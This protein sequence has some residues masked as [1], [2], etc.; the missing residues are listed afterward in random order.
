MSDLRER[1]RDLDSLDVPDVMQQARRLGPKTPMEPGPR[2][3]GRIAIAAFALL[4]AAA[5]VLYVTRAFERDEGSTPAVPTPEQPTRCRWTSTDLALP[6]SVTAKRGSARLVAGTS[7]EDLWVLASKNPWIDQYLLHYDGQGWSEVPLPGDLMT[8]FTADMV[9]PAPDEVWL[10]APDGVAQFDGTSWTRTVLPGLQDIG[11]DELRLVDLDAVS[12]DDAWLAGGVYDGAT[13]SRV[14][15]ILHWDGSAWTWS[16]RGSVG[17]DAPG[18]L[19]GLSAWG[20]EDVW[21]AGVTAGKLRAPVALHWD[22]TEWG[23]RAV[24]KPEARSTPS[25][26]FGIEAIGADDALMT[27][28]R[29][30]VRWDGNGWLDTGYEAPSEYD[31]PLVM[32]TGT[33]G[34]WAKVWN[35]GVARWDGHAWRERNLKSLYAYG[36]TV[37]DDA[38]VFAGNGPLRII[39][40]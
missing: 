5:S 15:A 40:C 26:V 38:A 13:E 6:A 4:V 2:P 22:G 20:P 25:K 3:A 24:R 32:E 12:A 33:S 8:Y 23:T 1:L 21:V 37:I 34:V 9:A 14:P 17:D 19:V 10:L 16:Y 29:G 27:V 36:M 28:D 31:I 35:T 30:V 11:E 7:M 39:D 18:R